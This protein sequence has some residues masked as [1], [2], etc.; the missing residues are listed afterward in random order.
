ML[1]T[2]LII[3]LPLAGLLSGLRHW[4]YGIHI[5]LLAA[6]SWWRFPSLEITIWHPYYIY[7]LGLSHLVLIT[8]ITF[9]AY[10]W[11]K[12]QAQRGGWRVP[13]KT[14]HALTFIGG[15][16]GALAGSK[17]FRH[18]T[19]KGAF[20]QMFVAVVIMQVIAVGLGIWI[21]NF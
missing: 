4:F 13:E 5:V 9:A 15:T 11:D 6:I 10:G 1:L 20:K 21:S 17:F 3:F 8:L 18:K 7:F 12:R 16:L 2:V 14:L 19:I